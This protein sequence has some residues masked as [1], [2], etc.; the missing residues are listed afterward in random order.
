MNKKDWDEMSF[1]EWGKIFP[2]F[3]PLNFDLIILDKIVS[4]LDR[5]HTLRKIAVLG[6]TPELRDI[7]GHR[8]LL[9]HGLEVK[10]VDQSKKMYCQM[11]QLRSFQSNESF[12]QSDWINFFSKQRSSLDLIIGDLTLRVLE[13][14]YLN[15]FIR[16]ARLSLVSSGYLLLRVHFKQSQKKV[17]K[18]IQSIFY[19]YEHS[20]LS[21]EKASSILFFLFSSLIEDK[22]EAVVLA[23]RLEIF[24][25]GINSKSHR[26]LI[27][28]FINRYSHMPFVFYERSEEEINCLFKKTFKHVIK[29]DSPCQFIKTS[30]L[31]QQKL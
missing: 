1:Q 3:R 10:V 13:N 23:S 5:S 15:R 11:N 14:D 22:T 19:A 7:V 30:I 27:E 25:N 6:S 26:L 29:I 17:F 18:S 28:Y 12:V 16:A 31:L 9:D 4:R 24:K 8:V 21:I 20:L 2:P